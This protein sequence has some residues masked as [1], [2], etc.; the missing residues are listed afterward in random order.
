M[1]RVLNIVT[2]WMLGFVILLAFDLFMESYPFEWL[3]WNGTTKNDWFFIMWWIM[4]LVWLVFG[5]SIIKNKIL[6]K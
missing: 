6:K 2:L 5:V 1:R 3:H 4:V